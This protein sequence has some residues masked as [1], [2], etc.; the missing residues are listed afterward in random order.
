M[1]FLILGFEKG[2]SIGYAGLTDRKDTA[3]NLP[4]NGLRT[5]TDLWNKVMKEVKL[6]HYSGPFKE[7]E[8]PFQ[9]Y[10]QSPIGL[11]PKAGGQTRLIFH[12]SYDFKN[13]NSSVNANT[14]KNVCSV[15][16][17]DLDHAI[18]VCIKLLKKHRR[19]TVLYYSKTDLKSA[20]RLV[21]VLVLHRRWLLLKA[22]NPDTGETVFFIDKCLP[23]G[24]SISCAVFQAFS[25]ALKHIAEY[26]MKLN[27]VLT[28][29]LDD[30][31]FVSFMRELCDKMMSTFLDLCK[32]I[33][34][35]VSEEKTE[36]SSTIIVFLGTL[37]DGNRHMLCI[38]EEKRNKAL[39]QVNRILHKR[40]ATVKEIQCLTGLL[41]FLNRAL[42]PGRVFTRRM[43]AKIHMTDKK[44]KKLKPY[45]HINLDSE[46]RKDLEIW[47]LFLEQAG[48]SALC[49]PFLD[50]NMFLTSEQLNFYTDASGKIGYGCFYDGRWMYGAWDR[51]FL[52]EAKPSIEFLEL[53]ALCAG[54]LTWAESL[55]NRRIIIFCDNQAVVEMVNQTTSKIACSYSEF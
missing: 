47:R 32:R 49:H 21:P 29:Y 40:K 37:L 50:R 38:P 51:K 44:G 5:Q 1:D 12:L 36:W 2:F 46:F 6:G 39:N 31:L 4:L 11:V 53:F 30:F 7:N 18:D 24:A 52:Q 3:Q 54:I 10:I 27:N 20:F 17:H 14:P 55:K 22:V 23:F 43:Y 34:C 48:S 26:L 16:Y 13:G 45:H 9:H 35:P 41:N 19:E 42:I 33:N 28:N 15:K 8:L 25:D